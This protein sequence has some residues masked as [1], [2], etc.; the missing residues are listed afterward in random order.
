MGNG[1]RREH[2]QSENQSGA[3]GDPRVQDE[4]VPTNEK[5]TLTNSAANFTSSIGQH[6]EASATWA[7]GQK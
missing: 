5:P 4:V 2:G 3:C 7:P 1:Q 6:H